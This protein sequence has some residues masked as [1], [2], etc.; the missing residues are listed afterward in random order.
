MRKKIKKLSDYSVFYLVLLVNLFSILALSMFNY[1]VFLNSSQRTYRKSFLNYNQKVTDLAFRNMDQQIMQVIYNIPQLY[2]SETKQND[3]FLK[4][5]E[6]NLEGQA[7]E[8]TDLISGLR[9]IQVSYPIIE[10]MDVY[11]ENTD[12]VVTGFSNVHFPENRE[13]LEKFLP[14]YQAFDQQD[15]D[16]YFM[17]ESTDV[18]P[19]YEPVLTYVRRIALPRWQGEG[20]V[21]AL[22][23]STSAFSDYM[24]E[25]VG[26]LRVYAPDGRILYQSPGHEDEAGENKTALT[27][28]SSTTSLSYEYAITDSVLYADVNTTNRVF[29]F[30]FILSILFNIV[31][32]L[33]ISRYSGRI[34]RERLVSLSEEA[35]VAVGAEHKSF[36]SSLQHLRKEIQSL[37][38]TANSSKALRFQS[39]VRALILNRRSDE[40][41]TVLEEYLNYECC[42]VLMIQWS[43]AERSSLEQIQNQLDLWGE[44]KGCHILLTT[45]EKGEVVGVANFPKD[46]ENTVLPR[47]VEILPTYFG[48][49]RVAVGTFCAAEKEEI[50][51]A[52]RSACETARYWFIYPNKS[53]LYGDDIQP[54]K[55][56]DK[57]SHLKLFEAIEKDINTENLLEFKLH[58]EMLVVSFQSGSYTMNY[59]YSTLRDLVTMICQIVQHRGLDMWVMYGYDIREYYK[60]IRDI[61]SFQEWM[62]GVCEILLKNIRQKRTMVDTDGEFKNR[63]TA[64]I[65]ENLENNISLDFLCDQLSMRPD[66]LSRIFKQVMGEGYTEYVKKQ[67]LNRAIAL[68]K[69]DYSIKEIA[70]KL[71]YSSSQYFIKIFKEVYGITPY[72]YK[73]NNFSGKN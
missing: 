29:L 9:L 35:G 33:A 45:M 57:G 31:L 43:E 18:Y 3:A 40:T 64:L 16:L 14:W 27:Y 13:E 67:K 53:V 19:V 49:C 41:Y 65:E 26:C 71:G 55:L 6:E 37:S 58:L 22:H 7:A 30:N 54:D 56:R 63:L 42:R 23:I 21:V 28:E 38:D 32:L 11:Y 20:I 36:D 25:N 44:E 59:C 62:N 34:Y 66:A 48:E 2:F 24:D 61:E 52:Y 69:D 10:S 68:M 12:T 72:Q 4:P 17:E 8:I 15:N 70:E 47:L 60:Q 39:A 1:F 73:K 46:Q 5:Q 51:K 50:K